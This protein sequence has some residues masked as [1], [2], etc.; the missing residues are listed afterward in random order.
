[1]AR[2]APPPRSA[3]KATASSRAAANSGRAAASSGPAAGRRRPALPRT[4]TSTRTRTRPRATGAVRRRFGGGRARP[5]A[6]VG[7]RL[8]RLRRW[9]FVAG[10]LVAGGLSV[11]LYELTRIP[12]PAAHQLALTTF[13]YDSG[14]RRIASFSEQNRVDVSLAQVPQIV[15]DA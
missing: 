10:L 9:V 4:R 8:W 5:P 7:G 3:R 1:M 11:G 13:V 15:I 2:P 12:L 6:I 14:G